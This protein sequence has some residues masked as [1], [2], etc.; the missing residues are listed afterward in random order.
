VSLLENL[1][2]KPG[3][4]RLPGSI[5]QNFQT[6]ESYFPAPFKVKES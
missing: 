5:F 1:T 3:K 2:K 4:S 6:V